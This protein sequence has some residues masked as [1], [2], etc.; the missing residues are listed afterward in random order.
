MI[1]CKVINLQLK[2]INL[3]LKIKNKKLPTNKS[4]GADS[5]TGEFYQTYKELISILFKL[6]QNLK[7]KKHSQRLMK[8]LSP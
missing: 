3:Y 6:F 8:P 4:P 2:E 7:R 5:F 1:Y